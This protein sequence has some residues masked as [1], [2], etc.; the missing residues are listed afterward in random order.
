MRPR[1]FYR[2]ASYRQTFNTESG[3]RVLAD[4]KRFCRA[5]APTADINNERATYLLEGRREVW[6]RI[7]AHLNLT[8][9]EIYVLTEEFPN[10]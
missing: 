10:E 5:N 8:D 2:R 3:K 6:L 4:L 1:I 9:E 7:Q